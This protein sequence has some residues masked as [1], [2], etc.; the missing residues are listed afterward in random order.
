MGLIAC[1]GFGL[2]GASVGLVWDLKLPTH[3]PVSVTGSSNL[4]SAGVQGIPGFLA[5][6]TE[7]S[8]ASECHFSMGGCGLAPILQFHVRLNY[9]TSTRE[10]LRGW[11]GINAAHQWGLQYNG[12]T[13]VFEGIDHWYNVTA[14]GFTR[15]DD[16]GWHEVK[17]LAHPNHMVLL[18]DG[19]QQFDAAGEYFTPTWPAILGVTHATFRYGIDVDNLVAI[20]S[21]DGVEP[22]DFL[23]E[24]IIVDPRPIADEAGCLWTPSSGASRYMMVDEATSDGDTTYN[25]SSTPDDADL[26]Q[27]QAISAP[28]GITAVYLRA[29]ARRSGSPGR[30]LTLRTKEDGVITDAGSHHLPLNYVPYVRR[31]QNA[32][33]GA[34]WTEARFNASRF[35]YRLVS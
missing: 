9:I 33:S 16:G 22:Y 11:N 17:I 2:I 28:Y 32:P 15:V 30:V 3:S 29:M 19:E 35:G 7:T 8:R 13:R 20:D 1:E 27:V 23:G 14:S 26:F 21:T 4:S 24:Q 18:V 25:A 12:G 31:M 5:L 34:A 6:W 10:I